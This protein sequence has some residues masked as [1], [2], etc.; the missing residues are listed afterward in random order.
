MRTGSLQK[1]LCG[2]CAMFVLSTPSFATEGHSY[3]GTSAA[4]SFA[5]LSHNAPQI[6]YFSGT[7]I[8][9]AYPLSGNNKTAAV[10]SINGGYEFNA[11]PAKP[12]IALGVGGYLN[13]G[14]YKFPGQVIE[15]AT[16][17]AS[18]LLYDYRYKVS[19]SRLMAEIQCLWDLFE[20]ISPYV[21]AGIGTSW[22]KLRSYKE[23]VVTQTGFVA[24]PAFQNNTQTQFAYQLG[25]GL[26]SHFKFLG[27]K[28]DIGLDRVSLGYRYVNLGTS[29]FGS[30]A[31]S[32]PYNLAIGTLATNEVYLGY[33]HIF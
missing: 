15:T 7:V 23:T 18:T 11:S 10:L 21:N 1:D 25:F 29:R 12:A 20:N 32:Y 26:S 4:A 8:N 19:S 33:T 28:R 30:R 16:G 3:L 5:H 22:K 13:A 24:L 14:Y 6:D 9:D 2:F 27:S 31:V 17:D